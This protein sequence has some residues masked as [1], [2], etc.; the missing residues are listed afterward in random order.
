MESYNTDNYGARS[1]G[2]VRT[3]SLLRNAYLWMALALAMTGVVAWF[4][5]SSE[6]ILS[7]IYSNAFVL[8]LVVMLQFGLVVYLSARIQRMS[9]GTA[10]FCFISYSIVTGLTFASIFYVY[11]GAVIAKAFFSAC[12]MFAGAGVFALVTKVNLARWQHILG[13]GLWGLFIAMLVNMFLGSD[14]LDYVV[15]VIGVVLFCGLT[16]WDTRR[17]V[18]LGDGAQADED[19][20]I[21]LSI[22]AALTLYLDFINMFLFLLRLYGRGN[23]N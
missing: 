20:F 3:T 8:F 16:A 14:T 12:L 19:S 4:T 23:R 10:V 11:T 5:A 15:S 1:K 6:Q 7:S 22:L 13:M 17:I 9:T 18:Q 21:K 2:V